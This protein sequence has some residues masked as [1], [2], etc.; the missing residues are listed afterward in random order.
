MKKNASMIHTEDGNKPPRTPGAF[1][2]KLKEILIRLVSPRSGKGLALRIVLSLVTP[3]AYLMLCGLVFDRW[4]RLYSMTTFIFFSY[5]ALTLAGLVIIVMSALRYV[6][7]RKR[8]TKAA[9]AESGKKQGKK[10]KG[11]K[12]SAEQQEAESKKE[13]AP[14]PESVAE[15]EPGEQMKIDDLPAATPDEAQKAPDEA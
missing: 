5:A 12:A 15:A 13:S 8:A 4:L 10:K 2:K 3:Y 6:K 14:P 9:D 7:G 11:M 1:K